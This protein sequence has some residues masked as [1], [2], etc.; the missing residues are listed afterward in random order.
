MARKDE[1]Q[2]TPEQLEQRR[3]SKNRLFVLLV[4]ID[5]FLLAYLI[6]EIFS[7]FSN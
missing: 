7:A 5:V 1:S 3:K 4:A 2:M 6:F